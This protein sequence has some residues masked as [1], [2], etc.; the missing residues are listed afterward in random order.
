MKPDKRTIVLRSI[1][2]L[3]L[4][5]CGA[6]RSR[7]QTN[8]NYVPYEFYTDVS[9]LTNGFAIVNADE[10]KALYGSDAQNVAYA[11]YAT[12]FASDRAVTMFKVDGNQT[13]GGYL[14][15]AITPAGGDYSL[16]GTNPCYFNAQPSIGGVTFILGKD[17]D[18]TDGST[19]KL[20][21]VAG[22]GWTIQCVAN[23]GYANSNATTQDDPYYWQFC[24]L[25]DASSSSSYVIYTGSNY[26]NSST[27]GTTTFNPSTCLWTGTSGST[28]QNGEGCYL[29]RNNN[30]NGSFS[31]T[32]SS[33]ANCTLS[34]T[35]SGTTGQKIRVGTNN[36][37]YLRFANS[38]WSTSNSNN[39]GNVV[40]TVTKKIYTSSSIFPNL[41]GDDT[42][43][44]TVSK[45]YS[46]TNA[47]YIPAYYDYMFY[48]GT[49]HYCTS[50]TSDAT[51][52]PTTETFTYTWS[53]LNEDGTAYTGSNVTQTNGVVKYQTLFDSDTNLILRLTATSTSKTFYVDK[54]INFKPKLPTTL[55]F[56]STA[57]TVVLGNTIQLPAV[58]LKSGETTLTGKTISYSA[59][60]CSVSQSGVVSNISMTGTSATVTA[61]F[62]GDDTYAAS[63]ATY[64][65][66]ISAHD[67]INE[68]IARDIVITPASAT[69]DLG[70]TQDYEVPASTLTLTRTCESYSELTFPVGKL[71]KKSDNSITTTEP[72]VTE[73]TGPA[74]SFANVSWN[75][76]GGRGNYFAVSSDYS[77]TSRV[78]TL[79][80]T[81]TKANDDLEYTITATVGYGSYTKT[82]TAKVLIPA[83]LVDIN[84]IH[85][86]SASIILGVD[87]TAN[88]SFTTEQADY[89]GKAYVNVTY[90][91]SNPSIATVDTN[92]KITG[93]TEGT[94]TVTIQS[95]K[96]DGTNGVS[97]TVTVE[98]SNGN[99][100]AD[101]PYKISSVTGLEKM[102]TYKDKA[103]II[104]ADFD[105]SG[106]DTE[107]TD[108]SGTLNG[109]Y[110]VISGL[111]QPLFVSTNN[112]TIK[113]VI[114]DNIKISGARTVN[115]TACLGAITCC[116][117]GSTKIYNCGVQASGSTYDE[118]GNIVTNSST[119]SGG[120]R[121]GS[122]VGYI[123][124]GANVRVVNNYSYADVTNGGYSGGIVGRNEATALTK[125]NITNSSHAA[126]TNNM[127]YGN[128][129]G[130]TTYTSP[131]YSGNHTSNVQNV[132]EYN[133][134]RN[135]AEVEYAYY[136]NQL[137]IDKDDYLNRF[138][139]YRHIQNT[140]RE[141]AAIYL[142]GSASEANVAEI[143][144]WYNE[145]T[146]PG[147]TNTCPYPI[148]QAWE[149]NTKKTTVEIE[150]NLPNTTD[151]YAGKLLTE[152]GSSGYLRVNWSVYGKSG[153][154]DLPITDMD[155]LNY[156]FTWGKV[157]L[158]FAN[159][160]ADRNT[161][162]NVCTGWKITGVTGGTAG[163]LTNYNFADRDCTAKDLYSN[164]GFIFAQGG[165][166]IVP[167]GVI[168]ISI[169]ANMAKAYY[170]RDESYDIGYNDTYGGATAVGGTI[171]G[172]YHGQNVYTDLNTLLN[173]MGTYSNPHSQ[174]I[175]LVGNYHYNQ[176]TIG[177]NRFSSYTGKGLTIM[178]VDEDNNQE[179]DY[180]WYS[181][182]TT[183]RTGVPPI[184]FDFVPNIGI[185]MAARTTGSTPYPTIGI[186]YGRGWFELTE[187]CVS[188]MSECEI[189]DAN[190]TQKDH[191][192]TRFIVNSG[193]FVQIV[194]GRQSTNNGLS[195][196][197]IGGNAYVKELYPGSHTDGGTTSYT[198]TVC[199]IVVTGGEIK[200]CYMT[201][202]KSG[203]SASGNI[204]FWCAGGKIEKFLGA[205]LEKPST[206]AN[207]T[208]KVDHALIGRFFGGGTST[209]AR[210]TGNIDITMNNSKVNFY[211]GGPEFGDMA[212]GKTVTTNSKGTTFGQYY[213]AG[214]GGTSITYYRENQTSS[215]FGSDLTYPEGFTYYT[216]NR[217]K[218]SHS[219]GVGTCYK[220]E[221]I[222]YSGGGGSGISRF[223]TGYASFSKAATGSVTNVLEDCI[224]ENNFYGG[225]C[226][227]NVLGSVSSTLKDCSVKGSAFGGGYKAPET[228]V[229]V[230][231]TTQPTYS[232]Y[233]KE[234][235]IFSDFGTIT[236]VPYK[237]VHSGATAGT[238]EVKCSFSES[239]MEDLGSV[240]GAISI[241]IDG[242]SIMGSV[243]GGGNESQAKGSTTVAITGDATVYNNVFGGG[244]LADVSGATAVNINGGTVTTAV[245]GGGAL[246]NTGNTTV[247]LNGGTV[248]DVYGGG[249]G[250]QASDTETAVAATVG[251]TTVNI[252]SGTPNT[253]TGLVSNLAGACKIT[254]SV[255]GCNNLN[256]T[257]TGD[258]T[259]NVFKTVAKGTETDAN[260][261][262]VLAVYGG[263]NKA[264][265]DPEPGQGTNSTK[266]THVNIYTC[267][268][269]IQY[270]YGGGNAAST[271]ATNVV[272]WGGTFDWVFG[273][274][275]GKTQE[276]QPYNMGANV[277]Y[278]QDTDKDD[279]KSHGAAYGTGKANTEIHDG[280]INHLF[281]GSNTRGNIREA[282]ISQLED[283]G[284]DFEIGEVYAAGNEAYM[285][286]EAI[287]N[288]GCIPGLGVL[289]GGARKADITNDVQLTITSGT[290]GKVF[291]GNNE[292]GKIH[293]TITVNIE[294]T[295]CHEIIIGEV[296][297][298]GNQAAYEG[299]VTVNAY[300][301]T[302]IGKLF[303]GGYGQGATV[304]GNTNVNVQQLKGTPNGV[305]S[306]SLGVVGEV[307]GGGNAADVI[308]NT[309]INIGTASNVT[310]DSDG[311]AQT[312]LGARIE[313]VDVVIPASI[314]G[315][316]DVTYHGSGNVYGGGNSAIVSGSTNITVGQ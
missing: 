82:A 307:Y 130:S 204:Y 112:A 39:G 159:E 64:N 15:R 92:G 105:A 7:G 179:P 127:F 38:A 308:G 60:G 313:A 311:T 262:H 162:A 146:V 43:E 147:Q 178:S 276:G 68:T 27:S 181:Y 77:S 150:N 246:A 33:S 23:N 264:A 258:A 289:Y 71:Y 6:A 304:T 29:R 61:R 98:V 286:G 177:G 72:A 277:G 70:G 67:A 83:I 148:I 219:L 81:T 257:P 184:R 173:A 157:V 272:I 215:S 69:L 31:V 111:T 136:N 281:G 20:N 128:L 170:L 279:V 79:T 252:G 155:S 241:T 250:R 254:G 266:S 140:H 172:Q 305:E 18:V 242:G 149:T 103:F 188:I 211:C 153:S 263:G 48:N 278:Y 144:H 216:N 190:Y 224:I 195:Y 222:L 220:F 194:R 234:T 50:L 208:A 245:Y 274:G 25:A 54:L 309:N 104:T 125:D 135:H 233:K 251:T 185:G 30:N 99:G 213:G 49:H 180:G 282:A 8:A 85:P 122:L 310:F 176:N 17:Q 101:N 270:V 235:G 249:L 186:W 156:D 227:G 175:V 96:I 100:Q 34:G 57:P 88:I 141:L 40:F 193:C 73:Q 22:S 117:M 256:G 62:A 108:F 142:F 302:Q 232:A 225:G 161:Y 107:I 197:Q 259:V 214:Y 269:S 154:V 285:D 137:A 166:Y 52:V 291:G 35:E 268:N 169:E 230:Y 129:K 14:L 9:Q 218:D 316:T 84:A 102:N 94:T 196:L 116:A 187:T 301:F 58:T 66:T 120:Q 78:T 314:T 315:S 131:T 110:K 273:G 42:F 80:R 165:N 192:M 113:N 296:Y 11:D 231:P 44:S 115:N 56:A 284:C 255:F 12:A 86:N 134:W 228:T 75:Y 207:M 206:G 1:F 26:L 132:N 36:N 55:S 109:N 290:Y 312:V 106:F 221:Y 292:S 24:S 283:L 3:L 237:W 212:T 236:P 299:T 118:N 63:E 37:G 32:T 200:E 280:V 93:L 21:Y 123:P 247:N 76:S 243:Y 198:T 205:Y 97:A 164:S 151:D 59:T 182:H 19:W 238:N 74:L 287:L 53:L 133:Y 89:D 174:A 51:T 126:I 199:P 143:G 203:S 152:M 124:S 306:G 267:D 87:E 303:G 139:F 297:G 223:Y 260:P 271:P 46:H 240:T 293:G 229:D 275:N 295:G 294:E 41:S 253:T 95:K 171:S 248:N 183:D 167:Y 244:N 91:S 10:S 47:S 191:N 114:L 138:P 158:P 300:S 168:A 261:Y 217:L 28:F 226:Q 13:N 239:E 145:K 210:I 288:M 265:Y 298:G 65:F 16:W 201:G 90:T 119:I 2:A 209:S 160:L 4:L 163:T 189:Q 121:T 5:V 45:T 202:Y